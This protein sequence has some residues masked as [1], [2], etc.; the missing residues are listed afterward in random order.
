MPEIPPL[1]AVKQMSRSR[2]ELWET[3]DYLVQIPDE[4]ISW[5]RNICYCP[6]S[7]ALSALTKYMVM[8]LAAAQASFA[9]ALATWRRGKY[10]YKFDE[11][12][13]Y[14][15]ASMTED[16]KIPTE[17][18]YQMPAQCIYIEFTSDPKPNYPAG[19]FAHIEHDV[20]TGEK[21]LRIHV[22]GK[23]GNCVSQHI[24]HLIPGGSINDGIDE[25]IN[26]IRKNSKNG[27][28]KSL[29]EFSAQYLDHV[30]SDTIQLVQLVL[31]ICAENAEIEENETQAKIYRKSNTIIDKYR[32]IRKYDV[33]VKTG[34]IL[35]RNEKSRNYIPATDRDKSNPAWQVRSHLRRAHWH[36]FWTGSGEN[37]KLILRWVNSVIVNP[38]LGEEAPITIIK[39]NNKEKK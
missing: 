19:F 13:M 17:I 5:D 30:R 36:H 1:E 22:I 24:I 38:Q 11:S 39:I 35:R 15:I 16:I 3:I 34:I 29:G 18:L 37:K 6:I 27:L 23:T 9:A 12:L 8:P 2:P 10:I 33:G 7:A 25:T 28:T 32:E 26:L 4:E 21:E 14:E 31:Y 20:N